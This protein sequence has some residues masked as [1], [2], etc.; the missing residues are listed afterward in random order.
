MAFSPKEQDIQETGFIHR[1]QRTQSISPTAVFLDGAANILNNIA[2]DNVNRKAKNEEASDDALRKAV[3]DGVDTVFNDSLTPV[4]ETLQGGAY[5]AGVPADALSKISSLKAAR[6]QG[7]LSDTYVTMRLSALSKSLK[8]RHPDQREKIDSLISGAAGT[9]QSNKQREALMAEDAAIR[10]EEAEQFKE[11]NKLIEESFILQDPE[12]MKMYEKTAKKKFSVD[13][14]NEGALKYVKNFQDYQKVTMEK[15]K[16]ALELMDKQDS[17]FS[18]TVKRTA[19]NEIMALRDKV[20]F[21]AVNDEGGLMDKIQKS[22]SAGMSDGVITPE[23]QTA[24]LT[25]INQGES[26]LKMAF[27]QFISSPDKSGNS[28]STYLSQPD[29]AAL[30]ERLMAP[31]MAMKDG[32]AGKDAKL[33]TLSIIK[34]EAEARRAPGAHPDDAKDTG[35]LERLEKMKKLYSPDFVEGVM[36]GVVNSKDDATETEKVLSAKIISYVAT[37][38]SLTEVIKEGVKNGSIEKPSAVA[39]AEKSIVSSILDNGTSK[40]QAATMA[41]SLYA[42]T[43]DNYL[44]QFAQA[45]PMKVFSERVSPEMTAKLKGTPAFEQ[46]TRWS[47]KQASI[48][49]KDAART[50]VGDERNTNQIDVS[51][52]GKSG[53]FSVVFNGEDVPSS[54]GRIAKE[55]PIRMFEDQIEYDRFQGTKK[56]VDKLNGYLDRMQTVLDTNG[57][58]RDDFVQGIIGDADVNAQIK[59]GSVLQRM[60]NGLHKWMESESPPA[61]PSKANPIS[62]DEYQKRLDAFNEKK[63]ME[64]KNSFESDQS[65]DAHDHNESEEPKKRSLK[66]LEDAPDQSSSIQGFKASGR[67]TH[68][69]NLSKLDKSL[70]EKMPSLREVW[71]EDLRINSGYRDSGTNKKVGGAKKSQHVHGKALDIDVSDWSIEKRKR[72]IQVARELGFG[73]VGV[74]KNAIHLDSGSRRAWGSDY[75]KNTIPKWALASL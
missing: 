54:L 66:E 59:E 25:Q 28:Y 43:E 70:A 33:S 19:N 71:G 56:A 15:E 20:L 69:L 6:E 10:K 52:D 73:G 61:R 72:F 30:E 51:Y 42:Q 32:F 62:P 18:K 46:Y 55:G 39:K 12:V 8:L 60:K 75:S 21:T 1:A 35:M 67:N 48:M 31:V 22:I 7:K 4:Q 14:L 27:Q 23:E 36:R 24:I 64:L 53:R 9:S 26:E 74:Y 50:V 37:G 13:D 65:D 40:E 44:E 2:K 16:S 47:Y 68:A 45:D 17:Q 49:M 29:V 11:R 57:D 38:G 41:N 5:D 63:Q 58:T 3:T 34:M